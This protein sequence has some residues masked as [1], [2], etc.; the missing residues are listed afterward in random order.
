MSDEYEAKVWR[1]ADGTWSVKMLRDG[2]AWNLSSC[3]ESREV[4]IEWARSEAK[5]DRAER[6]AESNAER[7]PV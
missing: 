1:V 3:F 5:K 2:I 6:N 4:A 7:V